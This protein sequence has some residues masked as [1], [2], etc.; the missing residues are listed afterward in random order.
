M[1]DLLP[2]K[3]MQRT[4]LRRAL[5]R[6]NPGSTADRSPPSFSASRRTPVSGLKAILIKLRPII[7]I[8]DDGRYPDSRQ[9]VVFPD[10]RD[11]SREELREMV[12]QEMAVLKEVGAEE[13][14][15]TID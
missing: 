4:R 7:V 11:K 8:E 9:E 15:R 13:A 12:R 10:L 1:V 2:N 3:P 6:C 5:R 14:V